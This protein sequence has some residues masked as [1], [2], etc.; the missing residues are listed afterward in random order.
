MVSSDQ[1][2]VVKMHMFS[3]SDQIH[4]PVACYC[5]ASYLLDYHGLTL[6]LACKSN[7]THYKMKLLIHSFQNSNSE[8]I[9]GWEW[10][11]NFI[12]NF[13]V[14]VITY[15]CRDLSWSY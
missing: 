10:R 4:Y 12:L 1:H 7:C 13:T 15:P 3:F 6:I 11:G 8:S 9:E 2:V 5:N 14:H